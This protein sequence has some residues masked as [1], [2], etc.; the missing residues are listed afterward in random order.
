MVQ[1]T[2][3]EFVFNLRVVIT[4]VIHVHEGARHVLHQLELLLKRLAD[5]VCLPVTNVEY[6]RADV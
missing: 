2:L 1:S 5:V 3:S 4:L 6:I